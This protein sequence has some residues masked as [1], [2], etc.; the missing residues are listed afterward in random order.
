MCTLDGTVERLVGAA[1]FLFEILHP[2]VV[3]QPPNALFGVVGG[4]VVDD[5]DLDA[6][7]RR[8]K[9]AFHRFFDETSVVVGGH[10]NAS[11]WVGHCPGKIAPS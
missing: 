6:V 8:F 10:E 7:E 3:R 4:T 5:D 11:D 2:L 1:I 9:S